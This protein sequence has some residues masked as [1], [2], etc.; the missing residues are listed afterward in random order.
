[1]RITILA[2]AVLALPSLAS[3]QSP[4]ASLTNGAAIVACEQQ[5]AGGPAAMHESRPDHAII[6]LTVLRQAAASLTAAGIPGGPFGVLVKTGGSNCNGYSCDIICAGNS[7][8]QRQWDVFGDVG[9]AS[10]PGFNGPLSPIIVRPC[11]F[12]AGVTPAPVTP[13]VDLSAILARLSALEAEV[14]ALKAADLDI[15]S[16]VA[17]ESRAIRALIAALPAPSVPC[18]SLPPY[19]GSGWFGSIT[20]KPVCR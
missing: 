16:V 20:S 5:R 14:A 9:G 12:V 2:L 6:T 7:S 17:V 13:P 10:T 8:Q 18:A 11:E 15:R 3:A 1:M 19:R 4:C